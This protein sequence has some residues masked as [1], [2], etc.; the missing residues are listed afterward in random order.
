MKR[1]NFCRVTINLD[2][3]I[4]ES[5]INSRLL[6]TFISKNQLDHNHSYMLLL[7]RQLWIIKAKNIYLTQ[8]SND[9][10]FSKLFLAKYSYLNQEEGPWIWNV[11]YI[12]GF[13]FILF[14][15]WTKVLFCVYVSH[16]IMFLLWHALNN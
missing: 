4:K 2:Y 16:K 5:E 7:L 15:H 6:Y 12:W 1:P 11:I 14:F 3:E 10:N 8:F 13:Y 9:N